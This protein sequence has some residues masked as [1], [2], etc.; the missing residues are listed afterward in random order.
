[1]KKIILGM[2]FAAFMMND[3]AAQ[4]TPYVRHGELLAGYRIK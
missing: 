2:A 3:A 1:M 4:V